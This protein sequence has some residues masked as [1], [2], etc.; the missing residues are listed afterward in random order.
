MNNKLLTWSLIIS[1]A[2]PTA[3]YAYDTDNNYQEK[4]TIQAST[5]IQ[6]LKQQELSPIEKMFNAE[7]SKNIIN[8]IG[9][10]VFDKGAF[11]SSNSKVSKDYTLNIGDKVDIFF[12][13]DS[14]D[15]IAITGNEFLKS[16]NDLTLSKDGTI[17][18]PGVGL[19]QAKGRTISAVEQ[20]ISKILQTKFNKINT[21][22]TLADQGN[23]PVIVTGSVKYKGTV[24]LNSNS[25][26][27]DGLSLAGGVLKSG[28]LREI[29]YI[30]GKNKSKLT[31]D[32][33]D[34]FLNGNL[35]NIK[36]NEGD[37]IFV[38]PIGKVAALKE[39]VNNPG[40]YEFKSNETLR[41]LLDY[42]GGLLPS[43]N[44]KLVN[45]ESFDDATGQRQQK[46]VPYKNLW[47]IKPSDGDSI[48]F[49][50]LYNAS[51]NLVSVEGNVKHPESVQ[52][53]Q[54]MK[55]S[56]IIKSKDELLSQTFADQAVIERI[57]G[58]DKS[59]SSIPVSLTDFF[60]GYIDPELKPQDKIKIY[61]STTSETIEVSGY[62][63]NPGL[64]PYQDGLTLKKLLGNV[65]FGNSSA[66]EP[67][68]NKDLNNYREIKTKN[69]V[70]EITGQDKQ[71]TTAGL[72][73]VNQNTDSEQ[74]NAPIPSADLKNT[75]LNNT[76]VQ[77][78]SLAPANKTKIV[79][80]YDL[81]VKNDSKYDLPINSGDKIMF[82]TL[83]PNET[84]ESV[85]VFG[86]VNAAGVYKFQEGMKLK[87]AIKLAGGLE[88]KGNLK[89]LVF[90][91]P[92]IAHDQR[93]NIE[94]SLMK[95]QEEISLKVNSLQTTNNNLSNTEIQGF[96]AS[97]KELLNIVKE[98]AQK[99]F[100]RLSTEIKSNNIDQIDDYSNIELKP[101]DELYI[102]YQSKHVV[103]MGAVLNNIA[104][105]Y[106]PKMTSDYYI[107][108]VGGYTDQAKKN[109]TYIIKVNGSVERIS[110]FNK[111]IME[112]GDT[113]VI[114]EKI[115]IPINWL[116]VTKSVAQIGGNILSSIFILTKI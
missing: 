54:G 110:K 45:V 104:L 18:I 98:K 7:D 106:K 32:L 114:P 21:K 26:I 116:E 23:F 87:D 113:I 94:D 52:Y 47:Y 72:I 96:L 16:S 13:G 25:T 24:Y 86:Y 70:V 36:F 61:P 2:L 115:S 69:I 20:D 105:T 95:L 31:L 35:K 42:A 53:K 43:V 107:K 64:L 73:N 6:G 60:N 88:Q 55:L 33:Y 22:V 28:S 89:G 62:I 67:V 3:G 38:K 90:L 84:V 97:Q 37:V 46:D 68:N 57:T 29:V 58:I 8:Q 83:E 41:H 76:S 9:Y 112:P 71:E 108:K 101:G 1:L 100:G 103:V 5:S 12:W 82:R 109:R 39:G 34:I 27:L 44:H 74:T 78:N 80:L 49:K 56:D 15:L 14:V 77:T 19:I 30:N 17:S 79:Y 66:F 91:R 75:N 4:Q 102:P 40:I 65:R 92:S 48:A 10:D 81:I 99:D 11:L 51:E 50:N 85:S 111:S 63:T 93:A 59:I